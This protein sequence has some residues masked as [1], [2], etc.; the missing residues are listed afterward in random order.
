MSA[1]A[2]P[3]TDWEYWAVVPAAGTGSRF[4]GPVAKQ[5]LPLAGRTVLDWSVASLLAMDWIAG[6][7][8]A[9]APGDSAAAGLRCMREGRVHR[10]DGGDSR[11]RSV[12]AAL[13]A[14]RRRCTSP[15]SCMVLVHDAARPC[16]RPDALQRLH[17]Q[18][19]DADGGLLAVPAADTLKAADAEDRVARTVP[20]EGI[21]QA[22][23]PQMFPLLRL[24]AALDAMLAAGEEPTDEAMA[25]ERAGARPRLVPGHADN[26]KLTWPEQTAMV[27]AVLRSRA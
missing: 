17:E 26:I 23:T 10:C 7:V 22:Q 4:G 20:R 12:R 6:V 13:D 9:T 5:Y 18:A 2:G 14:V 16:L 25:M 8:I 15:A 11:A 21:W 19:S 24:A 3:A 1:G 27:E